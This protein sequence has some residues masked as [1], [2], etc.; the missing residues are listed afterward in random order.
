[1]FSSKTLAPS[2]FV[3][4][5]VPDYSKIYCYIASRAR[6]STQAR[7]HAKAE[8]KMIFIEENP[9][10]NL[11]V[12]LSICLLQ[13]MATTDVLSDTPPRRKSG[14]WEVTVSHGPGRS[15]TMQTCIDQNSDDM[16]TQ[17][18][19]AEDQMKCSQPTFQKEGSSWV[20]ESVC[21][22]GESTG[23]TR[24]VFTG[25]FDTSYRVES[26]STYSPPL[27]G[28]KEATTIIDAKWL[29]PCKP[30]QTAGDVIMPGLGTMNMNKMMKG[31]AGNP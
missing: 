13:I 8:L 1:M 11:L 2:R 5:V 23:T 24:A 31:G 7:A 26:K 15:F 16:W 29:S 18:T 21:N 9:M 14:L 12:G 4:N 19:E 22:M 17:P 20:S 25:S 27:M 10:R 3:A 28:M 30:G 6:H